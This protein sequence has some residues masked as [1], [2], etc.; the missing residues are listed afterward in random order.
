MKDMQN[1]IVM[2]ISGGYVLVI[3]NNVIIQWFYKDFGTVPYKAQIGQQFSATYPL[4]V[5]SVLNFTQWTSTFA[6]IWIA[7]T[8]WNAST[9]TFSITNE[10]QNRHLYARCVLICI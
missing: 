6:S 9:M 5:K 8:S 3:N 2:L 1:I 7:T 4:T 10:Q